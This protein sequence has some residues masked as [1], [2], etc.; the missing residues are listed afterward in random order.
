MPTPPDHRLQAT[1]D[2][3]GNIVLR[4]TG[5]QNL[6]APRADAMTA[7]VRVTPLLPR[8]SLPAQPTVGLLW[9]ECETDTEPS[10]EE[11]RTVLV[12]GQKPDPTA[13]VKDMLKT[14]RTST[15]EALEEGMRQYANTIRNAAPVARDMN[16]STA[17]GLRALW[18]MLTQPVWIPGRNK[19]IK[20]Y[21]RGTL[22]A[23]DIVRFGGTFAMIFAV[24]FAGM[25]YESFWKIASSNAIKLVSGA[26]LGGTEVGV[27]RAHDRQAGN[28]LSYLP[29]VGPPENRLVIPKLNINVPIV[30]PPT[31]SLLRQDWTQVEEDIQEALEDGVVHYPGTA[32]AGQA[33]NFFIT[34]HSSY[35]AWAGG[36]Y[37]T[38]FARLHELNPGDEY[39]VFY[40]GDEHRYIVRSKTE[41]L[42]SDVSVLDQPANS[43]IATLMT[44]TPIG[45]TLRRLIVRAEEVDIHTGEPLQVGQRTGETLPE[46]PQLEALPI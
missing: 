5:A 2:E 18:N 24:L 34:G 25:N 17:R 15:H 11:E 31:A 37:K 35:Y 32:R 3:Y 10:W 36:S 27:F 21:S 26:S 40:G 28:L 30:N 43:R 4:T 46:R 23:L 45:T 39:T 33:G 1:Y 13:Y 20:E 6:P 19:T 42:P 44:C 8:A 41:V 9:N 16:A 14:L 22:F 12:T 7:Q 38:I 29:T